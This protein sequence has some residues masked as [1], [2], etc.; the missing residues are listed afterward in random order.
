MARFDVFEPQ[1]VGHCVAVPLA[2]F[3]CLAPRHLSPLPPLVRMPIDH[4]TVLPFAA[5]RR[6]LPF[7]LMDAGIETFPD[8]RDTAKK[9]GVGAHAPP[10]RCCRTAR[11]ARGSAKWG[12]GAP[13]A[14]A[15]GGE[16]GA[17]AIWQRAGRKASCS[18]VGA[19]S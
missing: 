11:R 4:T 10:Q 16:G 7:M 8:A 19:R 1:E 15:E 13:S 9:V 14:A 3:M 6:S 17:S 18:S 2:P 12:D 5:D